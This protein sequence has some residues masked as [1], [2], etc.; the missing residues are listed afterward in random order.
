MEKA[1]NISA[2]FST[3]KL[4]STAQSNAFLAWLL[5]SDFI[6]PSGVQ[7]GGQFS[8][9][10]MTMIKDLREMLE[11]WKQL[12]ENKNGDDSLQDF[13]WHTAVMD[14]K[15][16]A[17]E[18][19]QK[20][21]ES[22]NIPVSK[23]EL[24]TDEAIIRSSLRTLYELLLRVYPDL[25]SALGQD[26]GH[27]VRQNLA[28]GAETVEIRAREVKEHLRE[29]DDRM[30][31]LERQKEE[32]G[33]D[34]VQAEDD[35]ME[36]DAK[37]KFE[38][39]M[40]YT[41]KRGAQGIDVAQTTRDKTQELTEEG[42]GIFINRLKHATHPARTSPEFK[43]SLH[44]LL[45]LL[46]KWA[47]EKP[48]AVRESSA[49][50][51]LDAIPD[52]SGHLRP[53]LQAADRLF[54]RFTQGSFKE[55]LQVGGAFLSDIDSSR[56]LAELY[57]RADAYFRRLIDDVGYAES[58]ESTEDGRKLY[59]EW[60]QI[61]TDASS[62]NGRKLQE[63]L[64]RDSRNFVE[65]KDV[66]RVKTANVN[67][68]KTA[69]DWV[70]ILG[71]QGA[72][73]AAGSL[74]FTRDALK[75]LLD[76]LLPRVFAYVKSLP[77]PRTEYVSP[78]GEFVMENVNLSSVQILP[79]KI[80]VS[81]T[82]DTDISKKDTSSDANQHTTTHGHVVIRGGQFKAQDVSYWMKTKEVPLL[83]SDSGIADVS[84]PLE[85]FDATIAYKLSSKTGN[86]R[87]TFWE[88]TKV[89]VILHDFDLVI[90]ENQHSVLSK[91]FKGTLRS[92]VKKMFERTLENYLQ[93]AFDF[94]D[95]VAWDV[96][97]RYG[98]FKDTGLNDSAAFLGAVKSEIGYLS[99]QPSVWDGMRL[100]SV[101]IITDD[102]KSDKAFAVGAAPQLISGDKHGPLAHTTAESGVAMEVD[103]GTSRQA[104][105]IGAEAKGRVNSF[106]DAV[107]ARTEL[108][109][110]RDG[111]RT[112]AFDL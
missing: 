85:G 109:R 67:L 43:S 87:T 24:Q 13:L 97:K 96:R 98:V 101:G 88:V 81:Q 32:G 56:P 66:Q 48:P 38:D 69:I 60:K 99:Q 21:D 7:N 112:D 84:L 61:N 18:H 51:E 29:R 111:W 110:N 74:N 77:I 79:G 16:T 103:S 71:V 75:D 2:A 22:S 12:G 50:F 14:H 20:V 3:G 11:A 83:K 105:N 57:D 104:Q 107:T 10:G 30:G 45:D 49:S 70:G 58:E 55:L 90:R 59:N 65:D 73:Q 39:R 4:P 26:Y 82:I 63:I 27:F 17:K 19:T 95:H 89:D 68:G 91:L 92:G 40:D 46:R 35:K 106:K 53:A 100:T 25:A 44:S 72:E 52:P 102:P 78:E 23:E 31:E 76:V 41:K 8:E 9:K 108:E 15:A 5:E 54:S 93:L 86:E 80:K 37:E 64:E 1:A 94:A 47:R 33:G 36:R 6:K 42:R 62:P 28:S 34:L